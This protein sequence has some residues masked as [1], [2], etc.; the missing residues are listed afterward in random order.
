MIG[1]TDDTMAFFGFGGRSGAG[2][3]A[4]ADDERKVVGCRI[5]RGRS[6]RAA[7]GAAVVSG[8]GGRV[9]TEALAAA[10]DNQFLSQKAIGW[11]W[12]VVG[13]SMR[14]APGAVVLL[15]FG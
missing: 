14:A 11:W 7:P 15:V 2:T 12:T 8:F 13:W 5:V 9:G 4:A 10:D 1:W 3:L 6:V